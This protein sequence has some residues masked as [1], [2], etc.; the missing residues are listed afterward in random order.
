MTARERENA[1]LSF[2]K[3]LVRG[4]VEETFYPWTLT[5]ERF[6]KE[7]LSQTISDKFLTKKD[8]KSA[9]EKYLGVSWGNKVFELENFLGFDPV[10]RINFTLPLARRTNNESTIS[11]SSDWN[12]LKRFAEKELSVYFTDQ[13]INEVYG[14]LVS[15]HKKGRFPIRMNIEGFFWTPRELLG[16]EPH[17]YAFFDQPDLLHD[18]NGF[19]LDIYLEYLTKV[20]TILPADVLYIMEDLSGKNGPML[21]PELFDEFVGSY[22]RKLVPVLK[23]KGIRHVFVDSDGDFIKL[24]PYFLASGIEGFLPMDVNAGMDITAVRKEYPKLK[25]IGGYNKLCIAQGKDSIDRE[26]NRIMPVIRSGGYIPGAD[27]QVAPSTSLENYIYY[28]EKLKAAM[29]YCG[30]DIQL[31]NKI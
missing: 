8:E 12:Q 18:I 7:G 13:I 3:P 11:S 4:S 1:T 30:T 15:D 19:I 26:F 17:M 23:E 24:I 31:K 6:S 25:L 27:H 10:R 9:F 16:I 5:L 20:L 29:V 28:I 14:P 2:Q 22:Y 21:S